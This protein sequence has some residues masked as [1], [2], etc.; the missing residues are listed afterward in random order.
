[1]KW[2][3]GNVDQFSDIKSLDEKVISNKI[4]D[5]FKN[6]C[7]NSVH[8]NFLIGS[9]CSS[10]S[11]LMMDKMLEKICDESEIVKEK[12]DEFVN[13]INEKDS[14]NA[15]ENSN[16]ENFMNWLHGKAVYA[17][18]KGYDE[19]I[20]ICKKTIIE[21]IRS[22]TEKEETLMEY[23]LFYENLKMT[24]ESAIKTTRIM[25][26]IN[27]FTTNYDLFN[28]LAMEAAGVK[29][30]SGFA[31]EINR[32]FNI[33]NFNTRLVDIENR[34]KDKWDVI[35]LY[36]ML[37]KL[38]GSINWCQTS[39]TA[40]KQFDYKED[41]SNETLIYPTSNKITETLASPYAELFR[42]FS[43]ELQRAN[44]TLV[45]MGYGFSDNHVNNIIFQA[46]ENESFNLVVINSK[47]VL[48]KKMKEYINRP[49]VHFIFD[50][51]NGHY[52]CN[53]NEKIQKSFNLN[54]EYSGEKDGE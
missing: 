12:Y 42:K 30:T 38:H 46:L 9:G 6:M 21:E 13:F 20:D 33:N 23:K 39:E 7:V 5:K 51:K 50:D 25:E 29:Y 4:L 45:V 37:F 16:L 36:V 14:E 11:I 54:D 28:E 18:Q 52:F 15:K 22:G 26:P 1:M 47:D 17:N 10:S 2:L 34:Y 53:F 24:F 40:I 31:G 44:N 27:I 19:C 8:L 35:K 41:N 32:K 43:I 3:K 49:N 48:T